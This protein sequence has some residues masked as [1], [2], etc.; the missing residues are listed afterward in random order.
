MLTRE[1]ATDIV[2]ETM[3]ILGRNINIMDKDGIILSSGDD[4]RIDTFHEAAVEAIA[5]GKAVTIS[6]ENQDKWKGVKP[7][8][9]L[10]IK[11]QGEVIGVVGI[12]GTPAEV[13][14][15][16][17]LVV[18]MTE[19]MIQRIYY[20]NQV[21]WKIRTREF[22]I[23]E[24]LSE[25][26]PLPSIKQKCQLLDIELNEPLEIFVANVD[27]PKRNLLLREVYDE[28]SMGL[29]RS[30]CLYGFISS[31][32]L[33]VIFMGESCSQRE[34][35]YRKLNALLS[36]LYEKIRIGMGRQVTSI[37]NLYQSYRDIE[38][39]MKLSN[40]EKVEIHR[41][42]GELLLYHTKTS[43]RKQFQQMVLQSLPENFLN[44]MEV[45]FENNL[46]ISKTA[47]KL[48]I[49][50]NTLIYRL[51]KIQE[52][53]GYDPRNFKDGVTLQL[54]AWCV[55]SAQKIEQ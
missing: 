31:D 13:E 39:A 37:Q 20:M 22:L 36:R 46:N 2:Q 48:F 4:S 52:I 18:M 6:A 49:H 30:H 44:T 1:I 40:E 16:G 28:L 32:H 54:A 55:K 14:E 26:P 33:V 42:E 43:K 29:T 41:Y 50:R 21:E 10:P 24:I 27:Q 3:K 19:L 11:F 38:A 5:T 35:S 8:V 47:Q 12:S 9:N 51:D 25:N 45:F 53:T 23:E 7:G 34:K 15:F 17:S